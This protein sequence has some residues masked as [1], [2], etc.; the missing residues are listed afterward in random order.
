[1]LTAEQ[2]LAIAVLMMAAHDATTA[3]ADRRASARAFLAGGPM[4]DFWC[5][6]AGVTPH[7][8]R[9]RFAHAA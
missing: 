4:L 8:V 2:R 7:Q 1:M 6:L 9:R 5:V 3:T